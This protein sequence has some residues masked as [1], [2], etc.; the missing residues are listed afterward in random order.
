MQTTPTRYPA[1]AMVRVEQICGNPKKG[2]PGLLPI[3]RSTWWKWVQ[4]G[5]VPPGRKIGAG[6]TAWP[7]SV[8]LNIGEASTDV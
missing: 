2:S 8:V 6:V 1:D 7:V 3:S 4:D 5:H